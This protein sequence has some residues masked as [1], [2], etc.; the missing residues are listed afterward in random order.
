MLHGIN[1]RPADRYGLPQPIDEAFE[2]RVHLPLG[3]RNL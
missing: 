1:A 3:G 2:A